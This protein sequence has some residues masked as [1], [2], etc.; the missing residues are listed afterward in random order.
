MAS[1]C[2]PARGHPPL[3]VWPDPWL[4][5]PS[6]WPDPS[7]RPIRAALGLSPETLTLHKA[8]GHPVGARVQGLLPPSAP[9][10][11]LPCD[12]SAAW[13]RLVEDGGGGSGG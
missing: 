12:C 13:C 2:L 11:L 3:T 1:P 4:C 9:L 8:L 6:F 5:G 10:P 7:C